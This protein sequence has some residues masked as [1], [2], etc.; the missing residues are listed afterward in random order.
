M[1]DIRVFVDELNG[2]FTSSLTVGWRLCVDETMIK[3]RGN[4]DA[5]LLMPK[6]PIR[7][8]FKVWSLATPWG[9][10]LTQHLYSGHEDGV[11]GK[12]LTYKVVRELLEPYEGSDRTVAMD[13]YYT[14]PRLFLDLHNDGIHAVGSVRSDR[15]GF[16]KDLKAVKSSDIK[17][18]HSVYRQ[19]TAHP[20]MIAMVHR[21][22]KRIKEYLTTA[23]PISADGKMAD[24]AVPDRKGTGVIPQAL[25]QYNALMG[26]VDLANQY[27]ARPS[28]WRASHRWWTSIFLHYMTVSVVNAYYL[29]R[30]Y[31]NGDLKSLTVQQFRDLLATQLAGTFCNRKRRGRPSSRAV[32]VGKHTLAAAPRDATGRRARMGC[33]VCFKQKGK[34]GKQKESGSKSQYKC[35]ECNVAVCEPYIT[36]EGRL[37]SSCWDAHCSL[38]G[39]AAD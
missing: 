29:Y 32:S 9:Y 39:A 25:H 27:A 20:H 30:W 6:K 1:V 35:F 11:D 2:R 22:F 24:I 8:G 34:R 13:S 31:G 21:D 14:S 15:L 4:H 18:D 5:V 28:L 36:G 23:T 16:P 17:I 37:V 26:G 19:N 3:F 7:I 38:L 10:T 33:S 12:G